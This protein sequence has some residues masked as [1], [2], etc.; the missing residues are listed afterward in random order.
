M[1]MLLGKTMDDNLQ[2]NQDFMQEMQRVTM[3]RQIQMQNEM[4]ERMMA[5]QIAK[6]REMFSWLATFYLVA[7]VGMIRG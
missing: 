5:Q 7:T 1:G 2:K 3:E 4:R 6:S